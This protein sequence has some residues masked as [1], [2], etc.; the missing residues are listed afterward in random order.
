MVEALDA[1]GCALELVVLDASVGSE[2]DGKAVKVEDP[3]F[4]EDQVLE[5]DVWIEL[6]S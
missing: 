5:E 4:V 1:V 3:A 2:L 6:D